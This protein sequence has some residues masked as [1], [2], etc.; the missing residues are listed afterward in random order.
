[1]TT[2]QLINDKIVD[3]FQPIYLD[4]INESDNHNVP[5]GSESHFKLVVVSEAFTDTSL[6]QRHR[7]INKLLADQLAGAIHALSLHTHTPEE[8]EKRGGSV[9]TSPPCRGGSK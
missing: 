6:I 9:P 1:M 3:E 2:A 8:W 4:V 5:V 7:G